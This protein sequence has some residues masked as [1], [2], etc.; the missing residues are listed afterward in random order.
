MN[1]AETLAAMPAGELIDLI[2]RGLDA[3]EEAAKRVPQPY[4]LYVSAEGRVAEPLENDDEG[5]YAQWADGADR[6]PNHITNW[7][8]IYDPARVLVDVDSRRRTLVRCEEELL[9]GIP[10]LVHFAQETLRDMARPYLTQET[11]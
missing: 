5:G 10:R 6:M 3:D 7:D 9:S 2:R 1:A 4:R 8:L 11:P